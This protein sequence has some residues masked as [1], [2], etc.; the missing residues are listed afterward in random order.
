MRHTD[1]DVQKVYRVHPCGQHYPPWTP[2]G[3]LEAAAAASYTHSAFFRLS[4]EYRLKTMSESSSDS[5]ARE[6]GGSS[7]PNGVEPIGCL[8]S[9]GSGVHDVRA[10][11]LGGLAV[12]SDEN[13]LQILDLLSAYDLARQITVSKALLCFASHEPLWKALTLKVPPL[14]HC[15]TSSLCWSLSTCCNHRNVLCPRYPL[16]W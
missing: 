12:L 6:D 3:W 10:S 15:A 2:S 9:G 4:L 7:H 8:L 14:P 11:G 1:G 13:L 16:L 5:S